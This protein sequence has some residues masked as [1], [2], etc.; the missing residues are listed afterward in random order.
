[1]NCI[2][3]FTTTRYGG[4]FYAHRKA[5]MPADEAVDAA[6]HGDNQLRMKEME[7]RIGRIEE[8]F[9]KLAADVHTMK[10]NLAANT[11]FSREAAEGIEAIKQQLGQ[12]AQLDIP[13]LKDIAEYMNSMRG[14]VRVLGWLERP[15]R[16]VIAIAGAVGALYGIFKLKG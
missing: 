16:W 11:S 13:S 14:G 3:R 5:N 4:F 6:R 10:G 9:E 1:L 2:T 7:Q 15:A 12:L 8:G